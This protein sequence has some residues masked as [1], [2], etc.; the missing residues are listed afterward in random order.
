M[1]PSFFVCS[2]P[3][4]EGR[5]ERQVENEKGLTIFLLDNIH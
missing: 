4:D 3:S 2:A 5:R 1:F